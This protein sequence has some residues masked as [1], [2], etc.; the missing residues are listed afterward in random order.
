MEWIVAWKYYPNTKA[1]GDG[2][3]ILRRIDL[4]EAVERL[5]AVGIRNRPVI[6]DVLKALSGLSGGEVRFNVELALA[7]RSLH[8]V[9]MPNSL[10]ARSQNW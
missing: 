3:D 6:V 8:Q 5:W 4:E 7:P 9:D 10:F 2:Q 1:T